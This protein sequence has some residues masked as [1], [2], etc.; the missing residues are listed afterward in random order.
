M[1]SQSTDLVMIARGVSNGTS[2]N[3]TNQPRLADG[4]HLRFGF[5]RDRGFPW[6]GYYVFRRRH[7][8]GK[9]LCSYPPSRKQ[10][11]S[12]SMVW[13]TAQGEFSATGAGLVLDEVFAPA[14]QTEFDLRNSPHLLFRL[15]PGLGAREFRVTLGFY[16]DPRA[17]S[18]GGTDEIKSAP[19][20]RNGFL[21]SIRNLLARLVSLLQRWWGIRPRTIGPFQV[22]GWSG[23]AQVAY[24]EVSG[25]P[26]ATATATL[27]GDHLD[28]VEVTGA[29]GAY[30][31]CALI[32]VCHVPVEADIGSGWEPLRNFTYPLC[33]PN[34]QPAYPCSGRP[35]NAAQALALAQS[36][37]RYGPVS[38][39]DASRFGDMTFFL[40]GLLTGGPA[41]GAMAS[42]S[43]TMVQQNAG[44]DDPSLPS[45]YPLDMLLFGSLH[46]AVAQVLGLYWV[47]E[48]AVLGVAYDYIVLADHD[49]SFSGSP[50]IAL[51]ALGNWPLPAGV[52]AYIT[53]NV[54]KEP[55]PVLPPP[56]DP[57]CYAL[58][59]GAVASATAPPAAGA[60]TAGLTWTLPTGTDG[61]LL[62]GGAIYYHIWR[63]GPETAAPVSPPPLG[64]LL[65]A[66]APILVVDTES[67]VN[68]VVP[69][70]GDWPPFR[71]LA[72]DRNLPD[73][74]FSYRLA[75]VD[76]FGQF[77]A[78]SAP[79]AWYQWH[80]VPEPRPWYYSGSAP[81]TDA[82]VNPWAVQLRDTRPPPPPTGVEAYVLDPDD[83]LLVKDG[84]FGAWMSGGW[85]T[86]AAPQATRIGVRVK[87]RWTKSQQI[88]APDTVE[89][90]LY[91]HPGSALPGPDGR[92]PPDWDARIFTVSYGQY[93]SIDP[94]TG[95]HSYDVL[96]P[97]VGDGSF[98][99]LPLAP[100]N[101]HPVVYGH[102]GVS[103]ADDKTTT[104]DHIKWQTAQAW[105]P[106]G[107]GNR[108]GNEGRLAVPAK[109]YRVLRAPPPAPVL[110]DPS[111]RVWASRADYHSLSCYTF[112][113]PKPSGADVTL[114]DA[115]IF[116]AMDETLF[117][118]D[119]AQRPRALLD[120]TIF[121]G[122]PSDWDPAAITAELDGL[123]SLQGLS[124]KVA[125][126]T[127]LSLSDRALRVLASL[128][129]E[130]GPSGKPGNDGAFRQ[131]TEAPLKHAD[132]AQTDQ[133]GPDSAPTYVPDAGLCAFAAKLDG[134]AR[135]RY[136]FRAAYVNGAHSQGALGP[137]S[138][139]VYLH[140]VEPPREPVITKILGGDRQITL[141]FA[142]NREED[143]A[144][145][146]IYRADT[147]R[148][149]SDIRLMTLVGT[150]PE[151]IA[152]PALRP[153]ERI[154]TDQPVPGGT[155]VFYRLTAIDTS[156][157]ETP[158]SRMHT[159]R[160]VDKAPPLPP[161]WTRLEWVYLDEQGAEHPFTETVPQGAVW[162]KAV[163]A[164]WQ[165]N[166]PCAT[167]LQRRNL[168]STVWA[169]ASPWLAFSGFDSITNTWTYTA[170]DHAADSA[171]IVVFRLL[172]Q[173]AAGNLNTAFIEQQ[174][175]P[176]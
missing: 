110:T 107:F 135:N 152:D 34:A 122:F 27:T 113:W 63:A 123:N 50:Q 42:R 126:A 134:R 31:G 119:L 36:R 15:G 11:K 128:P 2:V 33:L 139:P 160:A 12:G 98:G 96:L 39:W 74:W 147:A 66:D 101:A 167:L 53:F 165:T 142:S 75:G 97:L 104:A 172:A 168:T 17:S 157:N 73:G 164:A 55:A 140:K 70:V 138:P 112:R 141:T 22:T 146:R 136:L 58:P 9:P 90:R 71:L 87:W 133:I 41:G 24:A 174:L 171:T 47:D 26:G 121:N 72:Y 84:A 103:A 137:S 114:V 8:S 106:Q 38:D 10:L 130:P 116:S 65:T 18:A 7:N 80:P 1:P 32:E 23:G 148:R 21:S 99:G 57:R 153:R 143:L 79:A 68:G 56:A 52:D 149:A 14:N 124:A 158:A 81:G 105:Q 170:Q 49:D 163:V 100:D 175:D 28:R 150:V 69:P 85:W 154:W 161:V 151:T 169:Q 155:D 16:P 40:D 94:T 111:D 156:G 6:H 48:S 117:T 45:V 30:G 5:D 93:A 91:F 25:P 176:A 54:K 86:Q 76:L 88:Q 46:P 109:I 61:D 82:V 64:T 77:S 173:S 19:G 108:S 59:G 4:V 125:L 92:D 102:I 115:H 83:P 162:K 144:E 67:S 131:I 95:D 89:F 78:A 43:T 3:P 20:D 13:Q 51:A 120:Q 166:E 37:V 159:A 60:N 129:A 29:G 62:P 44:P 145:Y 118:F 35:A 127:Y 132:A